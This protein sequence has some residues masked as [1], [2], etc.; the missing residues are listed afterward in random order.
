MADLLVQN[1]QIITVDEAR[2]VIP[3]GYVLVREG[4]IA[5][6]GPIEDWEGAQPEQTVDGS[7]KVLFPGLINTHD[8]MFQTLLKGLGTDRN[9]FSWYQNMTAPAACNLD[10]ETVYK[11]ALLACVESLRG[12]A[13][14][15]LDYMYAHPVPGL[16]DAVIQAFRDTGLRG[17]LGRGMNTVKDY[18][19]PPALVENEKDAIADCERL[20]KACHGAD[21]GMLSVCIAPSCVSMNTMALFEAAGD[22]SRRCGVG[23]T[24][25]ACE[26]PDDGR[27]SL[28]IHGLRELQVLDKAG[29]CNE[30]L[31]LVH[32]VCLNQQELRMVK[33]NNV[34]ISHAP[35]SNMYLADGVAPVPWMLE[36]GIPVGL[37]TDGPASNNSQD[38][39]ELLKFTALLHKVHSGD[40]TALTAEKVLEM[41]TVDGAKTV[42]KEGEIGAVAPG[43]RADFF[44]FD[45]MGSPK[46]VPMHDPVATLVYSSAQSCVD[47][48]VVNG[49]VLLSGGEFTALDEEQ[50]KA[51][52]A[53]AA[54]DLVRRGNIRA[55][56]ERWR[57]FT[58]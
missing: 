36:R 7:G 28:E 40:P 20:I 37:G 48:V 58:Y 24:V 52:A 54:R 6:V 42:W 56:P 43:M 26:S 53:Q 23:I 5:R 19:A 51:D 33:L 32:A 9:L 41:A 25:H 49:R 55:V 8:H 46:S 29:L 18:D 35:V 4:R 45:P 21:D 13:T 39:I 11:A 16:S 15:V 34:K 27:A 1:V 47:T 12:G 22:L 2:R 3:R 38:M 50:I 10:E 14:T 30:R 44:L 57:S 31:M 17:I